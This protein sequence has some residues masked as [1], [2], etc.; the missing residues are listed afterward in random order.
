MKSGVHCVLSANTNDDSYSNFLRENGSPSFLLIFLVITFSLLE[1]CSN[2]APLC[3]QNM[4]WSA[5]IILFIWKPSGDVIALLKTWVSLVILVKL[6]I[7]LFAFI[8]YP[9]LFASLY[10]PTTVLHVCC[11]SRFCSPLTYLGVISM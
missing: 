6:I 2:L 7:N 9:I 1:C 4:V 10:V 11:W 3:H 5:A 8:L